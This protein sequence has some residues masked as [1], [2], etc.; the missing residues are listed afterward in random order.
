M[1]GRKNMMESWTE[2]ERYAL[3]DFSS[4]TGVFTPRHTRAERSRD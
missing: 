3:A 4:L 2:R 1:F